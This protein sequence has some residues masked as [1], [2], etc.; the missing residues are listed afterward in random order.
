MMEVSGLVRKSIRD[1]VPYKPG[2]PISELEREMGLSDVAKLASNE[3]MEGPSAKAVRRMIEAIK[4][5]NY[6]PDGNAYCVKQAIA[7]KHNVP[8]DQIVVG[9]GSDDILV[10]LGQAFLEPGD[11][12]LSAHPSFLRYSQIALIAGAEFIG[13]PLVEFGYDLDAILDSVTEKTKMIFIANPNN[14]TGTI[15]RK[16]AADRFVKK[17][18][19]HVVAVFDEAY[20]D[21]IDDPEYPQSL[22]YLDKY[23]DK[24]IV[25]LRSLSKSYSLAGLRFGYGISNKEIIRYLDVVRGPFNVNTISQAAAIGCLEDA[26]HAARARISNSLERNFLYTEYERLGLR[27]IP[28]FANF[29]LVDMGTSGEAVYEKLMKRGVIVRPMKS[30]GLPDTFLRITIGTRSQ[31]ERLIDALELTLD[32]LKAGRTRCAA[33]KTSPDKAL[34]CGCSP[35]DMPPCC[36]RSTNTSEPP[37]SCGGAVSPVGGKK[38][39]R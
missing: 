2:K 8:A 31:N 34:A 3:N 24:N 30:W 4:E 14:P 17:L 21:Y 36:D 26:E 12:V 20:Y 1:I 11:I 33:R 10:M 35:F 29:I 37:S 38:K 18:P 22:E 27:F 32:E 5:L 25:V 23:P 9:N 6:Y 19:S 39:R 15:V 13:I 16:R 7:R 28:S